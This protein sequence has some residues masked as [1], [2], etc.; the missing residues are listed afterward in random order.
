MRTTLSMAICAVSVATLSLA[1]PSSAEGKSAVSGDASVLATPTPPYSTSQIRRTEQWRQT[2]SGVEY[3]FTGYENPAYKCGRTGVFTFTVVERADQQ[4]KPAPLWAR[5]H[6]GGVGYYLPDGTYLGGESH[7]DQESARYLGDVVLNDIGPTGTKDTIVG[8][9]VREGARVVATSMCDHDV[10]SGLGQ[11]Y[12]NN[13]NHTDTV[14][15]ALA[16]M[17]AVDAV[18]TGAAG[19]PRRPSTQIF[20]IGGSAGGYGSW[21]VA[22][23][24]HA[25]GV[26]LTG[27]LA[28]AGLSSTRM[29]TLHKAKLTPPSQEPRWNWLDQAAKIGPYAQQPALA[30]ERALAAGFPVPFL[31]VYMDGDAHCAGPVAPVP[32]AVQAGYNNNCRWAHGAVAEVTNPQGDPKQASIGYPGRGHTV[33]AIPGHPVQADAEAWYRAVMA[34]NPGPVVW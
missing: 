2:L 16:D 13:P 3:L 28:D 25:R 29:I 4:G 17:A 19:I 15:G 33:T 14:D 10:R 31:D 9:R 27:A 11:S 5:F 26:R 34:S 12:P 23:N 22:H 21:T 8:R 20:L 18:A 7:N 24:L 1:V 30:A 6:G 32:A